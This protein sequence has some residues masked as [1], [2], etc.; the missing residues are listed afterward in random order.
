MNNGKKRW[1]ESTD[2]ERSPRRLRGL[3]KIFASMV[4]AMLYL[5]AVFL[6]LA[7]APQGYHV[8]IILI[9]IIVFF[10]AGAALILSEVLPRRDE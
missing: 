1:P 6:A 7:A 5:A 4:G 3:T 10:V 9:S 8:W 2:W